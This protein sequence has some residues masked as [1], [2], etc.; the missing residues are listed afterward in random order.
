MTLHAPHSLEIKISCRTIF[1]NHCPALHPPLGRTRG[2]QTTS[3]AKGERTTPSAPWVLPSHKPP[4][5]GP[6]GTK[7]E[8]LQMQ[9]S[10]LAPGTGEREMV[11]TSP[12]GVLPT[13][14]H[15]IPFQGNLCPS[16]F[17]QEVARAHTWFLSENSR[18]NLSLPLACC[19]T[20]C[21]SLTLSGPRFP[22]PY[23]V[24]TSQ[25]RW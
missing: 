22:P 17:P 24:N 16:R 15:P 12:L 2:E 18:G 3:P 13:P 9:T 8:I 23:H 1:L 7:G 11:S 21:K 6:L 25:G 20:L 10:W 14:A 4:W 19:V 5:R